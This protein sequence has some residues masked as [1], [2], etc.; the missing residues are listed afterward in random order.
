MVARKSFSSLFLNI[1]YAYALLF[2]VYI[3]YNIINLAIIHL[4]GMAGDQVPLG[5]EPVLFG[6]FYLG[7]DLLLLQVKRILGHAFRGGARKTAK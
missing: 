3:L 6:L 2:L 7:F 5:V 1:I 4:T